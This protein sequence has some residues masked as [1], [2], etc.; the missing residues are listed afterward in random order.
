MCVCVCS[1]VRTRRNDFV[2]DRKDDRVIRKKKQ[3]EYQITYILRARVCV[4]E[5]E[6][7]RERGNETKRN[8][9]YSDRR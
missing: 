6:R 7:E 1:Y 4:C 9:F 3:K 5:R 8:A 2:Y